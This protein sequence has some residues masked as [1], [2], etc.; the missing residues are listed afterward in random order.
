MRA[1]L[2]LSAAVLE[3]ALL[4]VACSPQSEEWYLTAVPEAT[5]EAYTL[6]S[7]V[8]TKAEAAVAARRQLGGPHWFPVGT[9]R[10]VLVEAMDELA[11]S[12]Q[13]PVPGVD[14]PSSGTIKVWRVVFEGD[15]QILGPP[16]PDGIPYED[17]PPYHGCGYVLLRAANGWMFQGG[18]AAC[19]Q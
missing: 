17:P 16:P 8:E 13:E 3:A 9:P 18:G 12:S 5:L 14:D 15:W 10:V 7:P 11:S 6:G 19:P 2:A 1:Y 4:A